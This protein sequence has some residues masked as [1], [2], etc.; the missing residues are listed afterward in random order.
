MGAGLLVVVLAVAAPAP[1]GKPAD[2]PPGP[3]TDEQLAQSARNLRAIG[4]AMHSHETAHRSLPTDV[5]SKD[6]KPLLSW[7]VRLLP[8]L[9]HED[10]YKQFK[11]DEPWDGPANQKLI[12]KVPAV[13]APVRG[14]AAPGQTFYQA[15]GGKR[16][17]FAPG[18]RPRLAAIPDGASNTFLLAEAA[19]PV[20]WTKPQD[21]EFDGEAV[22]DLGG[23]FDGRF[24]AATG[25]G[26][27]IR[28]RTGVPAATLRL[29][30][31]PDDRTPLPAD[32]GEDRGPGR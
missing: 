1:K 19:R 13:Y 6:K 3:I 4:R 11:L 29:W 10:L 26:S 14:K 2:A 24:H 21:L 28:F 7:R 15:F 22:P 16:G 5:P 27:V 32:R 9:G 31:D 8:L 25:D 23:M 18:A 12:E 30:I 17:L 20:T